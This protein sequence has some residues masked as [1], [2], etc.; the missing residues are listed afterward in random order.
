MLSALSAIEQQVFIPIHRREGGWVYSDR[1]SDPGGPT[2][3]GCTLTTFNEWRRAERGQ[4]PLSRDEFHRLAAAGDAD[5]KD[6]IREVYAVRFIRPWAWLSPIALRELVTD[7]AVNCGNLN[8]AK[9]LQA[10]VGAER[11]GI[12]GA[13]TKRMTTRAV[14]RPNGLPLVACRFTRARLEHYARL[15]SRRPE[16]S[17]FLVGWSDRAMD[18]LEASI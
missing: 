15:A 5:L 9:F 7:A 12:A 17:E 6:A 4:G 10:A 2:F 3:G 8:A 11:D 18:C 14:K 16:L 1:P 13:N